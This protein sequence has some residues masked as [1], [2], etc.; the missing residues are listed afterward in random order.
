MEKNEWSEKMA[1]F[2]AIGEQLNASIGEDKNR[3]YDMTWSSYKIWDE[4]MSLAKSLGMKSVSE[5]A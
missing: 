4:A 1:Q 3:A 5:R 2:R